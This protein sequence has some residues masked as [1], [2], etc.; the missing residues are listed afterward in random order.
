MKKVTIK[1]I[2]ERC[3]VSPATVSLVLNNKTK[4]IGKNTVERV[5]KVAEEMG[6]ERNQVARSLVTKKS[7]TIAVVVPDVSNMFYASIIKAVS[8]VASEQMYSVIVCDTDNDVEEERRQLKLLEN[9][10]IDGILLA[11]RNSE[12]LLAIYPNK[13]RLPIVILDEHNDNL[14]DNVYVVAS[15]Y[16][17]SGYDMANYLIEK[18]HQNIFCFGGVIGSTNSIHREKGIRQALED[19][20]LPYSKKQIVLADYKMKKAYSIAKTLDVER[21]TAFICFNDLMAYGVMKAFLERGIKVPE[22]VSV[23]CFDNDTSFSLVSEL[24]QYT[25]TSINQDERQ[26]GRVAMTLLIEA[27]EGKKIDKKLHLLSSNWFIGSTVKDI[28]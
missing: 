2:A 6:Y 22:D 1:E 18:G 9:K 21:Y 16:V 3:Q 13:R 25:V 24:S 4:E 17:K 10:M 5:K 27:L 7:E 15:N 28:N 14:H 11:S 20:D 23:V 19:H 12:K 26:I 8:K